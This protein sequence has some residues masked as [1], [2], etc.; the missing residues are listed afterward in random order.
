MKSISFYLTLALL[1]YFLV[2]LL[3]FIFFDVLGS[4][5]GMDPITPESVVKIMLVGL[6]IFFASWATSGIYRKGQANQLQK[7][8][9]ELNKVKAKLYDLEHPKGTES[10][11]SSAPKSSEEGG[12]ILKP[13]QNFTNQ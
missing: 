2:F 5:F 3:F 11:S 12:G 4:T 6:L 10:K 1:I 9:Q 8:E 7:L 13:R